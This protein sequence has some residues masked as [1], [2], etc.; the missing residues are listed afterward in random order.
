MIDTA[1][2]IEAVLLDSEGDPG[3]EIEAAMEALAVFACVE[4]EM[5]EEAFV[6]LALK[7]YRFAASK[8]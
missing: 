3:D 6:D 7:S 8:E 2:A 1:K 4:C 5:T